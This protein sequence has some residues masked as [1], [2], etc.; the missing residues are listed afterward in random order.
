MKSMLKKY[1]TAV[2]ILAGVAACEDLTET[3]V[4]FVN[5]QT[6]YTSVG[7]CESALAASMN[8]L[9]SYWGGYSYGF[10][11]FIHDD[12]LYGGDLAI[13][14][15]FGNGLW[16]QHYLALNNINGVIRS[17]VGGSLQGQ[18]QAAIDG[19]L[20]QARFLRAFNYFTLVRLY[21]DL[22]L[23]TET[24]PDPV[25]NPIT[26]RTSKEQVYNLI[27]GDL[28]FAVDKL[29]V[30]WAGAPGKP[31]KGIAQG[32]LAKVYLTM[33][34]APLNQ[35]ENF[36]KARDMAKAVMESGTYSLLPNVFDVFKQENRYGPENLWSFIS[37]SDDIATD[38]QIWTPAIMDGWA[39]ISVE[40]LWA[41]N[42]LAARPDEPRQSAYLILEYDGVPYPD[43]EEAR[44]FVGKYV[45]PY[46]TQDQYN[47]YQ[48]TAVFPIMRFADVLLIYAEAANMAEGGP[49][50]EA[51]E[52]VNKVRRRAYNLNINTPDPAV[53]L[54]P[55]L[56]QGA[57]D[58]AV[59]EERDFELCFELDRWFDLVRKRMLA[60]VTAKYLPDVLGN[61]SDDDYLFPI[62]DLDARILG[63][64]NP[65]YSIE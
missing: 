50:A 12:Q 1:I 10:G 39:D 62:P 57:F 3:P 33:A 41:E 43:F 18:S 55:A 35:T 20:A 59:I 15:G 48:S 23:I 19:V 44:P 56:T 24:T 52:A 34:T 38:P 16:N 14:N 53:D 25:V 13:G 32:L 36:A 46:I 9:W 27:T 64:Q 31:A 6:F 37:T 30:S 40:P 45:M 42:W 7:Q 65:G 22:P 54:A 8:A 51:Y 47:N 11:S 63:S 21:G 61:V 5:E 49:S 29:P 26:S 4:G 28:E 17:V 58:V 2:L 60:E